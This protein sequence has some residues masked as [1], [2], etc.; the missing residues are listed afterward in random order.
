MNLYFEVDTLA[1]PALPDVTQGK[2]KNIR[3]YIDGKIEYRDVPIEVI[4]NVVEEKYT[5]LVS[6]KIKVI[7]D[8]KIAFL[9][10]K[11]QELVR[12][13]PELKFRMPVKP[14]RFV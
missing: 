6:K 10:R 8:Q 12:E 2:T 7:R 11:L 1:F 5:Q 3:V 13:A 4:F 9:Y 14:A